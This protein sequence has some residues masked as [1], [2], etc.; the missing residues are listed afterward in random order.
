MNRIVW[1]ITVFIFNFVNKNYTH[2]KLNFL[3]FN[4]ALNGPK[5]VDTCKTKQPTNQPYLKDIFQ[6]T[7][8]KTLLVSL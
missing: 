4:S 7:N 5:M 8:M 6:M 3:N 2:I 1:N